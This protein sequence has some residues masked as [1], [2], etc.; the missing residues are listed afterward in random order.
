MR[1]G[2]A[3]GRVGK[4]VAVLLS[5]VHRD[6]AR[7]NKMR[8]SDQVGCQFA[9]YGIGTLF[10]LFGNMTGKEMCG[11]VTDGKMYALPD[12]TVDRRAKVR[13]RQS[14]RRGIVQIGFRR[15]FRLRIGELDQVKYGRTVFRS[16]RVRIRKWRREVAHH[17]Y[18][19]EIRCVEFVAALVGDE[20]IVCERK[21]AAAAFRRC[22]IDHKTM[23]SRQAVEPAV[24]W[25]LGGLKPGVGCRDSFRC[26]HRNSGTDCRSSN[27]KAR[28]H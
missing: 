14:V 10:R 23:A 20:E 21:S 5:S 24:F 8:I 22:R 19:G 13:K 17:E 12:Q 9:I 7:G 4:S 1:P 2:L 16:D 15:L 25:M 18:D 27:A 26:A 3:L 28:K 11:H 6:D